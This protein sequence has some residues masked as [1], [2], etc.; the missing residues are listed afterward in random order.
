MLARMKPQVRRLAVIDKDRTWSASVPGDI[1]T[2]PRAADL[3]KSARRLRRFPI[4][5][6][7]II[8]SAGE[9]GCLQI[10]YE[11]RRKGHS[12]ALGRRL[13]QSR[14]EASSSRAAINSQTFVPQR[15][16]VREQRPWLKPRHWACP[17][18]SVGG[19]RQI[20]GR[21]AW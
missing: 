10:G 17:W 8:A 13:A 11:S 9:Q 19:V 18:P 3:R 7:R 2:E 21:W 20:D 12:P 5:R 1:A 6:G 16:V 4:L 15:T 14:C